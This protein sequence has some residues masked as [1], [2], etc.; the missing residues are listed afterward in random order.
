M[1]SQRRGGRG[2]LGTSGT[3]TG[4]RRCEHCRSGGRGRCAGSGLGRRSAACRLHHGD[5]AALGNLVADL[6]LH[7]FHDP[8]MRRRNLHRGLVA[9][10]RDEALL[11][12]DRVA[13]CNHDLDHG[14]LIEVSDVR[15][16]HI[17]RARAGGRHGGRRHGNRSRSRGR[18]HCLNRNRSRSRSGCRSRGRA[19]V[20]FEHQDQGAFA[21]LV[22]DL[23]LELFDHTRMR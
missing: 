3:A 17:D 19:C 11:Q 22:A 13:C 23:D 12:L 18:R 8:G 9:F 21:H 15:H 7:L 4:S 10:H 16:E 1:R 14:D 6:D 2:L 20:N 5:Q